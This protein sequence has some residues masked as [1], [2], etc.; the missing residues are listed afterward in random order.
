[1]AFVITQP[2]CNDAACTTACPVNCIHP[3]PHEPGFGTTEMLYIDPGGC[4]DCGACL[5]ACP[6]E[7][8]KPSRALTES[9]APFRDL[10]AAYYRDPAHRGY[11]ILRETPGVQTTTPSPSSRLLVAVV[12]SGP[13]GVHATSALLDSCGDAVRVDIF[14]RLTVPGGLVRYGVAPDHVR[15]R[16]MIQHF[17]NVAASRQVRVFTGVDVGRTLSHDTLAKRYHAVI[18]AIGAAEERRL[19]VPGSTLTG[20]HAARD[21]VWWYN[22]HPESSSKPFDLSSERAVIIGNGNVALDIARVLLDAETM[23]DTEL[24][25]L[26][27]AQLKESRIREV[28]VVG[29]RGAANAAFTTSELIGL[30]SSGV[31]V[32]TCRSDLTRYPAPESKQTWSPA[33]TKY[34]QIASLP[35]G[36]IGDRTVVLRFGLTLDAVLGEQAVTGVRLRRNRVVAE[37]AGRVRTEPTT[38]VEVVECGLL[39]ASVGFTGRPVAGLPFDRERGVIPNEQGR[40]LDPA[41]RTPLPGAYVAGWIKRGPTGFLGANRTCA[42]QTIRALLRDFNEGKLRD[43]SETDPVTMAVGGSQGRAGE[44]DD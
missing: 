5:V 7:A 34:D 3:T 10:N 16:R 2:C 20:H 14:E 21:L 29:R 15:T 24:S 41:H 30:A 43:P 1:M 37:D 12:G 39:I 28:V 22:G 31:D 33:R 25:D 18:Y 17:K 8:I 27:R 42:E 19:D 36:G 11:P 4:V 23:Q 6:V 9:E 38:E 32:L 44:D 40:V 26:A 35:E 13:A